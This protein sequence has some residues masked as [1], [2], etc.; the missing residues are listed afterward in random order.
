MVLFV[1]LIYGVLQTIPPSQ[2]PREMADDQSSVIEDLST[3]EITE[4]REAFALY[5]DDND[6]YIKMQELSLIMRALGQNPTTEHL[7]QMMDEADQ[8]GDGRIDFP[9][10]LALYDRRRRQYTN[11]TFSEILDAF[12]VFD[13]EKKNAIPKPKMK[14]ILLSLGDTTMSE[15]DID[16]M[17]DEADVDG[18][19]E[20]DLEE[21][22]RM[23]RK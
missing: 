14:E 1:F 6:G 5:D 20:V 7:Q 18:D 3:D 19:G 21:F 4:C 8:E 13:T 11:N 15:L 23:I 10:F 22:M 12:K 9:E 2:T 17:L 16:E